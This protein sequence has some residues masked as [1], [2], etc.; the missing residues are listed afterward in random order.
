M[1]CRLRPIYKTVHLIL[2]EFLGRCDRSPA[3]G[4][5]T[6]DVQ[7]SVR[8]LNNHLLDFSGVT[9]LRNDMGN[10]NAAR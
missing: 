5:P 9:L 3:A 4:R 6:P 10:D 7:G 2:K 1:G 8:N